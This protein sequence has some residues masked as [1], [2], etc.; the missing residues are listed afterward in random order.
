M[1]FFY[2]V[3]WSLCRVCAEVCDRNRKNNPFSEPNSVLLAMAKALH[4]K[5]LP[6]GDFPHLVCRQLVLYRDSTILFEN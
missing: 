1:F 3:D 4:G 5:S 2:S 6:R